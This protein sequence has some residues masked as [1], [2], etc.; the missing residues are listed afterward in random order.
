MSGKVA[1]YTIVDSPDD[2]GFYAE[3][4]GRDGRE[5]AQT[6]V[7]PTAARAAQQARDM[8]W[9]RGYEPQQHARPE[10]H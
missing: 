2:G 4:F 9:A 8:A 1:Y 6:E 7:L 3:L 10:S 5:I